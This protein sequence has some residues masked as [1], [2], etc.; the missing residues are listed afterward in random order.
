L[1]KQFTTGPHAINAHYT[2][3][4]TSHYRTNKSLSRYW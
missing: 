2:V 4:G 1:S 3:F